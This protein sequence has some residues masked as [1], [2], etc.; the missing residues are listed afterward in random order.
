MTAAATLDTASNARAGA[1]SPIIWRDAA[2][3]A[4]AQAIGLTL[5]DAAKRVDLGDAPPKAGLDRL[6][7]PGPGKRGKK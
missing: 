4:T 5:E 6:F 3:A 1:G 7:E 2:I